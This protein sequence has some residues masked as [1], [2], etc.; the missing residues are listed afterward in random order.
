M[1]KQTKKNPLPVGNR[2]PVRFKKSEA[3]RLV[4]ATLAAGLNVSRVEA[5]PTTGRIIVF[6]DD[7]PKQ[8]LAKE[9]EWDRI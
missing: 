2:G 6:S 9:S 1:R 7:K 8:E 3:T 5:C 4:K